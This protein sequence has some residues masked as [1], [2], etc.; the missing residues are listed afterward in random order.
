MK[1]NIFA[2]TCLFAAIFA[3]TGCDNLPTPEPPT[4]PTSTNSI[5]GKVLKDAQGVNGIDITLTAADGTKTTATSGSDGAFTFSGLAGGTY[6]LNW[7]PN[8]LPGGYTAV[9]A[10]AGS[11]G[12]TVVSSTEITG[13]TVS[14]G[15]VGTGYEFVVQ[16]T[17]TPPPTGTASISG[18][19]KETSANGDTLDSPDANFPGGKVTL[20]KQESDGT[21]ANT[22][23]SV[24]AKEVFEFTGVAAGTYQL[25]CEGSAGYK[26]NLVAAQNLPGQD[27]NV[28]NE[29]GFLTF[30]IEDGEVI[31]ETQITF[32]LCK[33]D[34]TS[35]LQQ[36]SA[37]LNPAMDDNDDDTN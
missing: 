29:V 2:L 28:E 30:L 15:A 22:G 23:K 21:F 13:I 17:T 37:P 5:S 25:Q 4:P 35:A 18:M 24:D 9:S 26:C 11:L 20:F 36:R 31:Q 16:E 14:S 12:G 7:T 33:K 3:F 27:T 8:G 19:I 34:T 32:G 1:R 10:V 6:S